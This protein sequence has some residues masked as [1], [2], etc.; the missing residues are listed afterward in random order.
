[1]LFPHRVSSEQ[2]AFIP[3][4]A[5]A[6]I[7][8][9]AGHD[10]SS[11]DP[12]FKDDYG[13]AIVNSLNEE[14]LMQAWMTTEPTDESW[15]GR[16][17]IVPKKVGR[18]WSIGSIGAAGALPAAKRQA[19][20]KNTIGM[21]DIYGVVSFERWVIEQS[22][23]KKGSFAQVMPQEME[24]LTDDLAFRRNVIAWGYGAGI[25]ALINGTM[26]AVTTLEVKAPLNVTGTTNANR[27][28]F[29]D[30]NGGMTISVLDPTTFAVKGTATITAVNTDGTDITV[31][32]AVTAADGDLIVLAQA[33]GQNS[34]GKE[35]EG[36][37]AGIDDGTYVGT[38]HGLSR[39]TYPGEKAHV[40]TSVGALSLDAI[41]QPIDAVSIKVGKTVDFFACE[42]AVRRAYL[43]LLE[44]DRRYTGADLMRPDGGTAA[45]KKPTGKAVTYGDI[46]F[47]V[48]RDCPYGMLFGINKGSWIRYSEDDGSWADEE[49]SVLKWIA[50]FDQYLA[51][52]KLFENYHCQQPNRNFRMEGITV[53]QLVVHAL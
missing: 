6:V 37:L 38:Y 10:L 1:M 11:F 25:L 19:Y 28:L 27:Y 31:D 35:P 34:Y 24:G 7:G 12:L 5:L 40:V 30:A 44:A 36:L 43:A 4:L 26:T 45:A 32:T 20:A 42:H 47:F 48:D 33:A 2:R 8:D 18:N 13:T 21:R 46:P 49:G 51:F 23:S 22:K 14:N 29:G 3:A 53:N 9:C 16:Q 39:T 52:Y 15:V 41:Q 17:K 50:G